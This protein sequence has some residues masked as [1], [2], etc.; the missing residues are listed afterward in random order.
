MVQFG[1]PLIRIHAP[2]LLKTRQS[3]YVD[4]P[5]IYIMSH[6]T[7][8]AHTFHLATEIERGNYPKVDL[9]M[10]SVQKVFFKAPN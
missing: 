8:V 1:F 2:Y 7:H 9:L 5:N 6:F 10:S 4:Y 3:L